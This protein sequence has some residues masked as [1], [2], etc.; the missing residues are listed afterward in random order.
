LFDLGSIPVTP[1][2]SEG[3]T[4]LKKFTA[5]YNA[6]E[7]AKRQEKFACPAPR[8]MTVAETNHPRERERKPISPWVHKEYLFVAG[9]RF[10][11]GRLVLVTNGASRLIGA[12]TTISVR[13]VA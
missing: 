2:A 3:R 4:S 6:A 9:R 7:E 1:V 8:R 11:N 13:L 12:W 10:R 5:E